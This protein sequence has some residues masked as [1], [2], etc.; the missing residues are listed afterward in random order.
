MRRLD[1]RLGT[2]G[3][4]AELASIGGCV[5]CTGNAPSFPARGP[6][7]P[8]YDPARSDARLPISPVLR[9]IPREAHG[10]SRRQ[11]SQS[12]LRVL[13]RLR[14]GRLQRAR[15]LVGGA[16]RDP[17]VGGAPRDFDVA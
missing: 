7:R 13:Y 2:T 10:I 15:S 1:D 9:T 3:S 5:G 17:L 8:G 6:L 4:R 12:A 16:V 14:R 11:M